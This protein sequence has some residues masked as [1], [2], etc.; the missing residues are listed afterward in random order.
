MIAHQ[1]YKYAEGVVKREIAA[2]KYVI[3][4]CEEFIKIC[5]GAS[6]KYFLDEDKLQQ[7]DKV[8]KML[9][10]PRGLKAGCSIYEC[11]CGYQWLF[12]AAILC[13][14]HREN[15]DRRRYE[16]AILEIARKNFK[17]FTIATIFV[18]LF[19]LEPKF[20]KFYSVAPDGALSREVKTAIEE[21]LKSS[22][23]IY[24]HN[25]R[26]PFGLCSPAPPES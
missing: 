4:Q 12:Y 23:L 6:R 24:L 3:K 15:P 22:P 10:M 20:S 21:I 2:P 16:T 7:I 13:I 19:L 14:V 5:D 9:V 17:T 25:E 18:L 1:S 8:L 11:S 26:L